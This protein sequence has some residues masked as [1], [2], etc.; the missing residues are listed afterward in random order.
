MVK[1]PETD[2][3]LVRPFARVHATERAKSYWPDIF[4]IQ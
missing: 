4:P 1:F 3:S 2:E